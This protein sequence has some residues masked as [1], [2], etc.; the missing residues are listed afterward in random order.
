MFVSYPV[1]FLYMI[2]TTTAIAINA[3]TTASTIMPAINPLST[4][5]SMIIS[6]KEIYDTKFS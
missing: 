6:V 3:I 5:R 1:F 4:E 2:H